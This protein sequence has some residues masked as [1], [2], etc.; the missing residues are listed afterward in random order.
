[1]YIL[2]RE[3]EVPNIHEYGVYVKDGGFA[4][5]KKALEMKPADVINTV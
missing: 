1:M 4:G 2:F 5:Y 3:K